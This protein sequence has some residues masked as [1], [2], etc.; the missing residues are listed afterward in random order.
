YKQ[1][2]RLTPQ[3]SYLP[4]NLGL[5]YQRLN[6]RKDA[7]ASYRTAMSLSPELAEPYNALGSLKASTGKAREAEQF[8][9][10]ALEKDPGLLAARH[11]LAL[12]LAGQKQRLPEAIGLWRENLTRTPDY[13]PSR[14]SLAGALPDPK[15]AIV[16]YRAALAVRPE[17]LAARLALAD[18]LQRTGDAGSALQ[19]LRQALKQDQRNAAIYERIGDIEAGQNHSAEARAAYESALRNADSQAAKRIRKK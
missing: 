18:L 2:I 9:R 16:E 19:E 6:R 4:Y 11:N 7:E 14:L 5:V 13:L 10:Q 17:Y 12:L 3:Y 15:E 8:Y 1:A